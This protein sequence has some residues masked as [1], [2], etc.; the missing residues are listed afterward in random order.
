MVIYADAQT[1]KHTTETGS[2]VSSTTFS[3][4]ILFDPVVPVTTTAYK[5]DH[6]NRHT[7]HFTATWLSTYKDTRRR[8]TMLHEN[9]NLP[10]VLQRV[11]TH[12]RKTM[13]PML[14]RVTTYRKST[15][16]HDNT[17]WPPMLQRVGTAAKSLSSTA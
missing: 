16:L 7:T 10:P 6:Q 9:T 12:W 13:P 3:S 11:C 4:M 15:I 2:N 5:C 17:N 14:P 8:S 1:R